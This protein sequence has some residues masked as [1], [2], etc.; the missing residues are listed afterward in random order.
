M[1][2]SG[3]VSFLRPSG[4]KKRPQRNKGSERRVRPSECH[5]IHLQMSLCALMGALCVLKSPVWFGFSALSGVVCKE[6][7][8]GPPKALIRPQ[9]QRWVSCLICLPFDQ[10]H[11]LVSAELMTFTFLVFKVQFPSC[12]CTGLTGYTDFLLC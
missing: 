4:R 6:T 3:R 12:C 10:R 8:I 11:S 5:R 2:G 7:E 1:G 9:E